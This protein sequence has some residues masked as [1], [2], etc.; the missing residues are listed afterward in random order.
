MRPWIVGWMGLALSG[1]ALHQLATQKR[2]W[3]EQQGSIA[4]AGIDGPLKV[5]RDELGVPHIRASTEN[6]ALYGL[7]LAHAQDR[8]FQAD[9]TRRLVSG[10]MSEMLG[11]RSV[12]LDAFALGLELPRRATEALQAMAPGERARVDAYVRGFNAGLASYDTLPIEYRLLGVDRVPEW[13]AEDCLS[14]AF[15]QSWNLSENS[16]GELALMQMEGTDWALRDE[17]MKFAAE[18]GPLDPAWPELAESLSLGRFTAGWYAWTGTFG[19]GVDASQASNNWVIGPSRSADGSPIVANDPH[20]VQSV[21]SLWYA[22]DVKGG[23]LHVAGVTFPG[24]PVVIIG[25][26]ADIAWGL[27][28]VMADYVDFAVFDR[29][30][31]DAVAYGG[32]QVALREVE[33]EV[34]VRDSEPV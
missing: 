21:P 32:E 24:T 2:A 34:E 4:V 13:T 17:A 1:C 3:P 30:G 12:E 28:N 15:L 5:I 16:R 7:G 23:D 6:D 10:R 29:V 31:L 18:T 20:L 22:A 9:L 27:T 33:V 26:N 11:A 8:L 19:G 14:S 25:H